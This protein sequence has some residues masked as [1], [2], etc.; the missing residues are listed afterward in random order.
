MNIAGIGTWKGWIYSE[1]LNNAVKYGYQ[2]KILKGYKFKKT[3]IFKEYVE[4]MYNLISQYSKNNPMNIIAKLFM[5]SLYGKFGV[6]PEHSIIEMYDAL[7]KSL[8]PQ[9][10]K[11][12][13]YV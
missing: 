1:E 12:A 11:G 10:P 2:F 9:G 13:K 5:N 8:R 6:R 4:K 3:I 7:D